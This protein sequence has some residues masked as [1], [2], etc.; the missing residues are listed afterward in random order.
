MYV[1]QLMGGLGNQ[2]FEYSAAYVAAKHKLQNLKIDKRYYLDTSKRFHRFQYRPY[3]LSL[4]NIPSEE[5]TFQEI[6]QFVLPRF[7][8]KYLY[9]LLK[10]LHRDHNV[11][12]EKVLATYNDLINISTDDA[13]L[14]G[15]FQ[16]YEYFSNHLDEIKRIFT[17]KDPLPESYN[18]VIQAISQT[19]NSICIVFRRGDYVGHPTLDIINLE[20]YYQ[21][22]DILRS[23]INDINIFVFSD[24]IPWC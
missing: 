24:D 21:A 20:F 12:N 17:F 22:I 11:Y 18:E 10:N 3:A 8:N 13:Y 14:T 9:H 15:Y 6:N 2:L 1:I 7:R 4:F 23:F 5:A 16:K 19:D